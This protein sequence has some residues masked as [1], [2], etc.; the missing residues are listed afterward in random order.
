MPGPGQSEPYELP[1]LAFKLD[2]VV[3]LSPPPNPTTIVQA[4]QPIEL[5]V[6]LG[7][8]GY[9]AGLLVGEGFSV[10]H[11][12][13]REEDGARKTLPG[14]SSVVPGPPD[15]AS[16]NVTTG[17]F[18]TGQAGSGA[19]LEIPSGYDAGTFEILTHIHFTDPAKRPIV[20][21]FH[22]IYLMVT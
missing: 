2:N 7:V 10:F 13:E 8:E 18:T 6:D 16:F 22:E 19:D 4:G 3:A 17:P 1:F 12:T 5:R 9:W 20:A 14:R 21:A 11:H 15:T